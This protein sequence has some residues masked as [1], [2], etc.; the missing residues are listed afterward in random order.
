MASSMYLYLCVYMI[1]VRSDLY[2]QFT[3]QL[4]ND[5]NWKCIRSHNKAEATKRSKKKEENNGP[6]WER[7]REGVVVN[8]NAKRSTAT[9]VVGGHQQGITKILFGE[10]RNKFSLRDGNER[11]KKNRRVSIV[12]EWN[13]R[14]NATSKINT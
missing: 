5:W 10:S 2:F 13:T 7:E 11:R 1:F 6:E 9:I 12:T 3:F 4:K 14:K 8:S